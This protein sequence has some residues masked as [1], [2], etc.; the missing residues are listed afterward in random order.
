VSERATARVGT[1][2]AELVVAYVEAHNAHDPD[3][4]GGLYA[5]DGRHR[6]IATGGERTGHSEIAGGLVRFFAAFPDAR[7]EVGVPLLDGDRAAVP[8]RLTATLTSRMGPFEPAG[9]RLDL[10]GLYLIELAPDGIA[11]SADYWD[12]ATFAR[13]MRPPPDTHESQ[14]EKNDD[15]EQRQ[16]PG[17]APRRE[18]SGA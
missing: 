6:E 1:A 4:V 16:R 13:Q 18:R 3:A 2:V 11:S 10:A 14:E 15:S 17:G 5:P 9:Q 12:A 8:Y 7:W